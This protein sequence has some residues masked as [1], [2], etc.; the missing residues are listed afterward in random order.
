[1][2]EEKRRHE[3]EK[4]LIMED[5]QWRQDYLECV[6]WLLKREHKLVKKRTTRNF[7]NPKSFKNYVKGAREAA[8]Q[9]VSKSYDPELFGEPIDADLS[10]WSNMCQSGGIQQRQQKELLTRAAQAQF[11]GMNDEIAELAR[12]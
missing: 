4:A 5:L 10:N 12:D 9:I 11:Y 7:K 6:D 2:S 3:E 8:R 1:M